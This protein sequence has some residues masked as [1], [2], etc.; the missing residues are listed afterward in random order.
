[1]C[2]PPAARCPRAAGNKETTKP[3]PQSERQPRLPV[4]EIGAGPWSLGHGEAVPSVSCRGSGRPAPAQASQLSPRGGGSGAQA[5]GT[6]PG[7]AAPAKAARAR[8]LR[9]APWPLV[10]GPR[11]FA[12]SG[13]G[14]PSGGLGRPPRPPQAS[15]GPAAAASTGSG[16]PEVLSREAGPRKPAGLGFIAAVRVPDWP[17]RFANFPR[18]A[19]RCRWERRWRCSRSH[20]PRSTPATRGFEQERPRASPWPWLGGAGPR[21]RAGAQARAV[22]ARARPSGSRA[23]ATPAACSFGGFGRVLGSPRLSKTQAR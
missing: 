15:R 4:R 3:G 17:G 23:A 18:R 19:G 14:G 21:A 10:R 1:M 5:R 11:V 20:A 12:G 9:R 22:G 2:G 16:G 13:A 6:P 7:P 8:S